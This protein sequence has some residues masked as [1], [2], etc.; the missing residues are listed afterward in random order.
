MAGYVGRTLA[1]RPFE[2]LG[3]DYGT[4]AS[5]TLDS[6]ILQETEPRPAESVEDRITV[7]R[8]PVRAFVLEKFGG[9]SSGSLGTS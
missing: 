6:K 9:L 5:L 7:E 2:L 3:L 1:K 8:S 4:F